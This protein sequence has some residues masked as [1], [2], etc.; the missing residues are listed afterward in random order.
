MEWFSE[1][2]IGAGGD[3]IEITSRDEGSNQ[4]RL[5]GTIATRI[6]VYEDNGITVIVSQL[7]II[8]SDQFPMSSVTCRVNSRGPNITVSFN[9]TG[10]KT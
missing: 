5:G 4:T 1:D 10:I 6:G 3:F 7:H 9:I 2:Y 8:A